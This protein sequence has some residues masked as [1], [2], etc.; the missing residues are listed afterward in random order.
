MELG[1][2]EIEIVRDGKPAKVE[3]DLDPNRF[4]LKESVRLEKVVG[5]KEIQKIFSGAEVEVSFEMFQAMLW[6]KLATVAPDIGI[7]DFDLDLSAMVEALGE[8]D[9]DE[10]EELDETELSELVDQV[11]TELFNDAAPA[12]LAT[13]GEGGQ[14]KL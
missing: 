3:I 4:T 5:K 2:L 9:E 8:D 10:L 1:R 12:D 14:G 11:E 6:A 7:D 13:V